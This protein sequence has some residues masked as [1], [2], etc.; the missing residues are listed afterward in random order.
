MHMGIKDKLTKM[1]TDYFFEKNGDRLTQVQ[2]NV[3]SVKVEQKSILWIFHKLIVT[4]L[5]RPERSKNVIKCIYKRSRWFKKPE[6]MALN[7][8]NLIIAQGLKG[9]KGKVKSNSETI[10]IMNIMNLTTKKSLVPMEN[11]AMP[12]QVKQFKRY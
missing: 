4:F 6:F 5:V 1:S 7:Q 10:E 3:V 9:V 2:G 11:G 12:K 8:G